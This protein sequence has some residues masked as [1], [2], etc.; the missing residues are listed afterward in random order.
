[1]RA[2]TV[3]ASCHPFFDFTFMI[4]SLKHCKKYLG[5]ILLNE[6]MKLHLFLFKFSIKIG[7][8]KAVPN[9]K[10]LLYNTSAEYRFQMIYNK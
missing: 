4:Q 8:Y 6:K 10:L 1:M 5:K 7:C 3:W 2:I 9:L